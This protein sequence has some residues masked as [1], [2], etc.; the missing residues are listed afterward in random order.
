MMCF[1]LHSVLKIIIITNTQP[2]NLS[3][4]FNWAIKKTG[5]LGKQNTCWPIFCMTIQCV[6]QATIIN[7]HIMD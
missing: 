3:P 7:N 6:W 5:K 2:Q 1:F 4:Q